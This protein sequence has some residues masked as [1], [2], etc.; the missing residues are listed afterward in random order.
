[1][2]SSGS[3]KTLSSPSSQ[4]TFECSIGFIAYF[5]TT[6]FSVTGG[7]ITNNYAGGGACPRAYITSKIPN[8][9]RLPGRG[10]PWVTTRPVF[11][12]HIG[13]LCCFIATSCEGVQ[14][15]PHPGSVSSE[16][17]IFG[18]CAFGDRNSEHTRILLNSRQRRL[19]PLKNQ[20]S[21]PR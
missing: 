12:V 11:M 16:N 19:R 1:L 21:P 13:C 7:V 14:F 6:V 15:W 10:A 20:L 4:S 2:T 8:P 17:G 3:T 5:S 9:T 18:A